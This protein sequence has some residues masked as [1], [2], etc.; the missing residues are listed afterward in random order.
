[1]KRGSAALVMAA[2]CGVL[3][4]GTGFAQ[5]VGERVRVTL[6]DPLTFE[7]VVTR[8]TPDQLELSLPWGDSR[9]V[10][11]GDVLRIER[12][13]G[14][15]HWKRGFLVGATVGA[16]MAFVVQFG[17]AGSRPPFAEQLAYR[18]LLA[19]YVAP[20]F[21]MVGAAVGGLIKREG[22]APVQGWPLSGTTPGLRL[23][24]HTMPEGSAVLALGMELRF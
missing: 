22:W 2:A 8:I 10:A 11:T 16:S 12:R 24:M 21:G 3:M 13:A 4:P 17:Y 19:A 15:R 7:G 14:R 6:A 9:V 23:G 1:M 18:L 5:L 20:V